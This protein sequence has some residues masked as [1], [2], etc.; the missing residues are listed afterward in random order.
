MLVPELSGGG[1]GTNGQKIEIATE[2]IYLGQLI[3]WENKTEKNR[4][5][6]LLRLEKIFGE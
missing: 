1:K 4:E 3:T 2:V 6:N 5:T